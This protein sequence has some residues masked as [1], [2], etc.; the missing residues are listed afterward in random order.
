MYVI[1]PLTQLCMHM[2]IIGSD[3]DMT[4]DTFADKDQ[5]GRVQ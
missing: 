1:Q 2:H 3:E 5:Y 4:T